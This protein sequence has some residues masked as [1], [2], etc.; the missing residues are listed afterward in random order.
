MRAT[1]KEQSYSDREKFLRDRA[2]TP[3]RT[4]VSIA[5]VAESEVADTRAELH[6]VVDVWVPGA[7]PDESIALYKRAQKIAADERFAAI[8]KLQSAL[9][10]LVSEP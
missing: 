10:K 2:G 3:V 4:T 6:I 1:P 7:E 9:Q 5:C 8:A